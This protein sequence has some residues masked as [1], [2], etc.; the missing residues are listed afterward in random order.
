[1]RE[2]V[3]ALVETWAQAARGDITRIAADTGAD[4]TMLVELL[5]YNLSR[6]V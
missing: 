4:V 2:K 6:S 3:A 5:D 1:V